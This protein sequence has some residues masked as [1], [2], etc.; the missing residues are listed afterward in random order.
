MR[1]MVCEGCFSLAQPPGIRKG[2][3]HDK[4]GTYDIEVSV[5]KK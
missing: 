2:Q 4:S 3:S 1:G 5:G